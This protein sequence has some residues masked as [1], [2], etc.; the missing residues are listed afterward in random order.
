MDRVVKHCKTPSRCK[1]SKKLA[2]KSHHG[3]HAVTYLD[4]C[5]GGQHGDA[6]LH[7]HGDGGVDAPGEGDV[8]DG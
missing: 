7:G 5:E 2:K 4:L 8:D 3:T 6:P 1:G